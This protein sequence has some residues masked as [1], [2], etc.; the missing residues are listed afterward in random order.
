MVKILVEQQKLPLKLALKL[1]DLPR[2][3]YYYQSQRTDESQLGTD[4]NEV[5]GQF[6]TYGT[7]RVTQQLRRGP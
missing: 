7:R 4:P 5:A 3:T 2:S 1:L 6:P